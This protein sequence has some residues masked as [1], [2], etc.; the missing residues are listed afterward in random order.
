MDNEII[1]LAANGLK[2]DGD[3]PSED[4]VSVIIELYFKEL[5]LTLE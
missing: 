5:T 3:G 4:S 2:P 1:T